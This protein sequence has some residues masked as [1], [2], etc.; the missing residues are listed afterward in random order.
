M[1][2]LGLQNLL[3]FQRGLFW[4]TGHGRVQV[5]VADLARLVKQLETTC[6]IVA[7]NI[8]LV[9]DDVLRRMVYSI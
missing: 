5:V 3:F 4:D 6:A 8:D 1:R 9:R 7:G 2:C